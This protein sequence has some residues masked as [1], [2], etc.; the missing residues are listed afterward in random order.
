MSGISI[1]ISVIDSKYGFRQ[2]CEIS[3]EKFKEFTNNQQTNQ[4]FIIITD[5]LLE[6]TSLYNKKIDEGLATLERIRSL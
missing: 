1:K 6:M 4:P 5:L 3:L 2:E